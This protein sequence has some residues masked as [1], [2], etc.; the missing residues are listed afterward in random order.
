[1]QNNFGRFVLH[2][3]ALKRS[4]LVPK[5]LNDNFFITSQMKLPGHASDLNVIWKIKH[6][7]LLELQ[8]KSTTFVRQHTLNKQYNSTN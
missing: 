4:R 6:V 5:T 3:K 8:K 1:M 7:S 2:R